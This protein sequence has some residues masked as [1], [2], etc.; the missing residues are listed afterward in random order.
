[1]TVWPATL[2]GLESEE[3]SERVLYEPHLT[4]L[5]F[6]TKNQKTIKTARKTERARIVPTLGAQLLPLELD[7]VATLMWGVAE[8]ME[9][10]A[11]LHGES[12]QRAH[13]LARASAMASRWAKEMRENVRL[14]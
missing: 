9:H 3:S 7:A 8:R 10:V 5:Q 12:V 1:M 14:K 13:D 6:M 11:T 4:P 2:C